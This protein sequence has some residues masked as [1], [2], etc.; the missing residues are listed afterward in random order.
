MEDLL[1]K[2]EFKNICKCKQCLIDIATY[3]LNRLPAKYFS[4]YQGEIQTKISE[5][6]SQLQ[7]DVITT[8]TKA[9]KKIS[10]EPRH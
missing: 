1:E 8:V 7:V 5:F 10:S 6:E 9:I 2:P 4:S 3:V